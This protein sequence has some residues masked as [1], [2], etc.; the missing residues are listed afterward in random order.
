[1]S[2]VTEP[3]FAV[4]ALTSS[5]ADLE[6]GRRL[7]HEYV[8]ATAREMTG[9]GEEPDLGM[10]IPHIPDYH[11]FAA[12]YTVPGTAFLIAER[13]GAVA[14]GVGI[15]QLDETTCE[16]NRLWVRPEQQGCGAGRILAAESLV[17]ARALGYR[18][19]LLDVLPSRARPLA[20]YGS[21]GFTST[22]SVHEYA[23]EM[24]SL[25]IDL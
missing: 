25:G 10:I 3:S 17:H 22:P 24:I 14:G 23:F 15:S 11:D 16:M 19:M 8:E 2:A 13:G 1:M 7:V 4:R 9:P 18:R 5:A 20:L 12:R 6:I 21:L